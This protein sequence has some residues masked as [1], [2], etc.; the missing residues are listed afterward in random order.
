MRG[1]TVGPV[2]VST[3]QWESMIGMLERAQV[4]FD[5]VK[6]R[7]PADLRV[8]AR[9][10]LFRAPRLGAASVVLDSR[11]RGNRIDSHTEI[12]LDGYHR[13]ANS[14]A[15][16]QFALANPDVRVSTH[17]HS[18]GAII[19]ACRHQIP[20]IVLIRD[21]YDAVPSLM[22]LMVGTRPSSAIRMWTRYY[23]VVEPYLDRV[24]VADFGEVIEDFGGVVRRCNV[25]WGTAFVEPHP[26]VDFENSVRAKIAESWQGHPGVPLPS[27][28]RRS[29]ESIRADLSPPERAALEAAHDLYESIK[30]RYVAPAD[31]RG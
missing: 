11:T 9:T 27:S 18:P 28:R 12:V 19:T 7:V 2:R 10:A 20:A 15:G 17:I 13:S 16:T 29:S 30:A 25:K 24:V 8:R 26:S 4:A 23:S 14:F 5:R 6:Q 22:Q 31:G 3:T 1:T 21:P